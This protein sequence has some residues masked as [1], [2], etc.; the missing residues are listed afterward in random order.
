MQEAPMTKQ[1]F[2]KLYYFT[3][4]QLVTVLNTKKNDYPFMVE[5]RHFII[6]A[7]AKEKLPGTVANIYLDQMT[8]IRAQ[9]D[10]R[11]N[12]LS[13]FMLMKRYYDEL[14]VDVENLINEVDL[15]PAY[16]KD[17]PEHM[18]VE[19]PSEVPPWS[20]PGTS[21]I[22]ET[23]SDMKNTYEGKLPSEDIEKEF[24][25]DGVRFKYIYTKTGKK[26]YYKNGKLTNETEYAKAASM[27]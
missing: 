27:L 4:F 6:R 16:L 12:F 21:S 19:T 22:P 3:P 20:V 13:D 26:M 25:L 5:G 11:M 7:G 10:D 14:I 23:N 1:E 24:E 17:I 8:R 18:K 15:T 9:D 2:W